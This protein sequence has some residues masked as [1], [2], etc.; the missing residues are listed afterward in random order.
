MKL[1]LMLLTT[2]TP[3]RNSLNCE[4]YE[5]PHDSMRYWNEKFFGTQQHGGWSDYVC[6]DSITCWIIEKSQGF[7]VGLFRISGSVRAYA[8][9]I[10]SS[11]A[12]A[13][14]HIVGNKCTYC[15]ERF[16]E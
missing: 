14:L 7:T 9:L 12:S 10:L 5:V 16:S 11:Q 2:L 3:V 8:Y 6:P 15:P 1:V 4:D 13:K